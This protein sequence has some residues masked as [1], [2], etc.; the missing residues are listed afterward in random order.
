MPAHSSH[1]LQPLDVGCFAPLKKAYGNEVNKLI[2]NGINHISKVEFLPAFHAAFDASII[3]DNIRG[4]FRGAGLVP[5]D[6]EAVIS[7]LDIRIGTPLPPADEVTSWS[8]K[9]PVN[10]VQMDSQTKL[11][12]RKIIQHQ[13]SSPTPITEAVDQLLKGSERIA[14]ELELLKT[15]FKALRKANEAVTCRKRRKK[16]CIQSRGTLTKAEGARLAEQSNIGS[17]IMQDS[18]Q[19]CSPQ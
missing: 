5:Y 6:P 19:G 12:K 14:T 8:P 4:G 18:R 7:K 15:E 2:R 3:P 9:T 1:L 11:I 10:R 16:R 13:D 17:Q